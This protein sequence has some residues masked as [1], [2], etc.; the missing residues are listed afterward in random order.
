MIGFRKIVMYNKQVVNFKLIRESV[1]NKY[2]TDIRNLK[3]L[4]FKFIMK[5]LY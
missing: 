1:E 4:Y 5:F 2:L 3:K